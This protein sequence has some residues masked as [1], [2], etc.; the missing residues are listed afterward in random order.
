MSATK[1]ATLS[2]TH[3]VLKGLQHH[4]AAKIIKLPSTVSSE[5]RNAPVASHLKLSDYFFKIDQS[6][7]PVW[8]A[9]MF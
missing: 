7:H 6:P 9:R 5:I 4:L 8:A 3:A 1:H 2:S